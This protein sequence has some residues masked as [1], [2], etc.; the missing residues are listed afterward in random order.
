MVT[1]RR[2]GGRLEYRARAAIAAHGKRAALDRTLDRPFLRRRQPFVALKAHFRGPALPGRIQL[3]GFP[4]GYC[5]M[6]EV[7]E[8]GQANVCLL[9]HES[10]LRRR[11]A[12]R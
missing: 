10:V 5:G 1:V 4:G 11:A 8:P 2:N 3:H 6:S 12:A 7:E 9:A